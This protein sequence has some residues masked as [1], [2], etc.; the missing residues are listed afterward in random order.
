MTT[1]FHRS[2][3]HD[4]RRNIQTG[5]R[6]QQTR[7]DLVARTQQHHGVQLMGLNHQFHIVGDQLAGR[8]DIVH[9]DVAL[10]DAIAGGNQSEL[11]RCTG[12]LQDALLHIF[13]NQLQVVVPGHDT[14]P[15]IGDADQR[16]REVFIAVPHRFINR[17]LNRP[18]GSAQDA[19]TPQFGHRLA[20]GVPFLSHSVPQVTDA[21]SLT[22]P[23]FVRRACC[24][25]VRSTRD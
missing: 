15:R 10:S 16:P 12:C 17:A 4:D 9:P 7:D 5:C 24:E 3:H 20:H 13:G 14:V 11:D 22:S 19:L 8:Q 23:V 1:S 21:L 25:K 2:P 18:F 6:H